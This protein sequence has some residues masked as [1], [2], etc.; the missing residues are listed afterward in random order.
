VF[1]LVQE[2]NTIILI[3]KKYFDLFGVII[4]GLVLMAKLELWLC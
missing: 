1:F 2:T 3:K 4:L